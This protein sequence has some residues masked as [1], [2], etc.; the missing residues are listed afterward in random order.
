M[1][2]EID[3][4]A[5][6]MGRATVPCQTCGTRVSELRRGRCWGCYSRWQEA[7]PVGRGASC[8][9]CAERRRSEL[10]LAELHGRSRA[11]CHSCAGQMARLSK[12]PDSLPEIRALLRRER[13]EGDRRDGSD[14]GRIFPRERRVGERRGPPRGADTDPRMLLPDF[15]DIVIE[16][17][18][19]DIEQVEQTLV[20][21]RP[22][23]IP[24]EALPAE[25][26]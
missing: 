26:S 19:A 6:Q 21:E 18:D 7:R 5:L 11:V 14:D 12:V 25:R 15:E 9:V 20:R 2:V 24:R 1:S 17:A 16:L 10:R 4:A 22:P 23:A 13:R 3:E 8:A